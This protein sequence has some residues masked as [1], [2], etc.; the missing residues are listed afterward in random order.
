MVAFSTT[1]L[2]VQTIQQPIRIFEISGYQSCH[3]EQN[4]GYHVKEHGKLY[5]KQVLNVT[6]HLVWGHL[7]E[8]QTVPPI[9]KNT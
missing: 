5:Q 1:F 3:R 2:L 9:Y 7:A 6:L 4:A 8:K